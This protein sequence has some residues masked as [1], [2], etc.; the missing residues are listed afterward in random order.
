MCIY[1]IN[2]IILSKE[3]ARSSLSGSGGQHKVYLR[4]SNVLWG[5][6]APHQRTNSSLW[7]RFQQKGKHPISFY[8]HTVSSLSKLNFFHNRPDFGFPARGVQVYLQICILVFCSAVLSVGK[9]SK[10]VYLCVS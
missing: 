2:E 5:I 10:S 9:C 7:E 1:Y 4:C 8:C 3:G 6:R